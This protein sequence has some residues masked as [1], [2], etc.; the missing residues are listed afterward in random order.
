MKAVLSNYGQ[1]P[2]KTRLVTDL[3]KGKKVGEALTVDRRRQQRGD[4]VLARAL[5]A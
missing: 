5:V 1:S 4:E 3:V 2:R